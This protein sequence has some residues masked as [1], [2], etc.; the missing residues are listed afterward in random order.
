MKR[1]SKI[2]WWFNLYQSTLLLISCTWMK[3]SI[4]SLDEEWY[5]VLPIA[6]IIL[7]IVLAMMSIIELKSLYRNE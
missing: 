6:G 7:S 5:R 1:N 2:I 4:P 3:L